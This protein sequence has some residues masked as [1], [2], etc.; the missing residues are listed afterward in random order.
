MKE[1]ACPMCGKPNPPDLDTCQFCD[2]R[3][4]PLTDELSRSQPP[5]RPGEQPTPK[6]TAELEPILP[7]WLRQVRQQAKEAAEEETEQAA[8]Q[9]E[10]AEQP[11]AVDLLAGLQSPS[12]D[13][14][15][16]PD[17]LLNLRGQKHPQAE[18]KPPAESK[19]PA[20]EENRAEALPGW[21]A[22]L[23]SAASAP[24]QDV[25][26][27]L[28]EW[29][30]SREKR[31]ETA[32]PESS[33]A[34]LPDLDWRAGL[35]AGFEPEAESPDAADLDV[36][37]PDWLKSTEP[38]A[39]SQPAS[40]P[41]F[42][43]QPPQPAADL[44]DWL[45][46]L[47]QGTQAEPETPALREEPVQPAADMP[48][49]LA[50]LGQ[51][52]EASSQPAS[53]PAFTEQ[54]TPPSA[55]LPDWLAASTPESEP[56]SESSVS[57]FTEEPLPLSA[58]AI[59]DWLT[60][61]E[62][63]VSTSDEEQVPE[64]G[65][66][67]DWMA[68]LGQKEQPSPGQEAA[69]IPAF[70]DDEGTPLSSRDVDAIF[71]LEMPD[72]LSD[73]G[74]GEQS[75]TP[76]EESGESPLS[77]AELPSWVRAMRPVEAVLSEGET[78][79]SE[80]PLEEKGPL[81]GLRGVLPLPAQ[82]IPSSKPKP[83]SLKLRASEE[84]QNS[85]SLLE[86]LLVGESYP[87]PMKTM[88]AAFSQRLLKQ[89]LALLLLLAV[90]IPIFLNTN[91]A[92]VPF[93][94]P[95]ETNAAKQFVESNLPPDAAVLVVF[96]YEA[97]LAGEL[98]AS[99][100]PLIDYMV[101]LKHPRLCLL[102]TTPIGAGL[103]ERFMKLGNTQV[104]TYYQAGQSYVNLGFLPGGAAGALAFAE[105]P[106]ETKPLDLNGQPAWETPVLQNVRQLSQFAAVILLTD[107]AD[108]ARLWIEQTQGKMGQ[109]SLLVVSSAQ[110]GPMLQPYV[111]S[112]QI[113]GLV[114]GLGSSAPIEQINSGRPGL[115][116]RYWDAYGMG[117]MT[118]ILLISMGGMWN[119][120]VY[121]RSRQREH[122]K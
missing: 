62:Q 65:Q 40:T 44:P 70:V 96:D 104:S 102:S 1:I 67:T 72:W 113:D 94:V 46:S 100:A 120:A 48:D 112:Q 89:L 38:E 16:I 69:S 118:A 93:S 81:A 31:E 77:P 47:E 6:S 55:D 83:Y 103:S 22:D 99:A 20:A 35:E 42:S 24:A 5:I 95:N 78:A 88:E 121:W 57:A 3:L 101:L 115:A 37:L 90:G 106:A 111:Q 41:A 108:S 12:E 58:E 79:V 76:A 23:G 85:A 21:I 117:L 15:E 105:N 97:A 36:D 17:W 63:A 29:L 116:R 4:R 61:M 114:V 19:T 92:A 98:E 51:E 66:T 9:E 87:Q 26:N 52:P 50:A 75:K 13:E 109:A 53:T 119:L 86:Q 84:Q 39:A 54:P 27:E 122:G 43:E 74:S 14:E 10:A 71:S 73:I 34:S 8:A 11:E 7:Q 110:A 45:A 91:M 49:W 59:P 33:S 32:P 60:S 56:R 107:D 82:V 68:V 80:Q 18:E 64:T 2:A 30:A 28:A 25:Q